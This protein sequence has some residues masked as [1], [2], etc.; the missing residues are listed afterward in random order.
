MTEIEA[1]GAGLTLNIPEEAVITGLVCI[2]TY[3]LIDEDGDAAAGT[4]WGTSAMPRV[5][6]V[7]MLRLATIDVE[8]TA[9]E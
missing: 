4:T 3:Q 1:G 5:Q 9:T 8:R 7:G 2:A 6:A